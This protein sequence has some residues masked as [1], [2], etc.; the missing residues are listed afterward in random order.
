[1]GGF[2]DQVHQVR[3]AVAEFVNAQIVTIPT[4]EDT[5][6]WVCGSETVNVI[7]D[8]SQQLFI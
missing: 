2:G 3:E 6:L 5:S 4:N 1:M 7:L 8:V